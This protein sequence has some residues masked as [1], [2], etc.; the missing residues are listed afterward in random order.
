MMGFFTD[1]LGRQTVFQ[2]PNLPI[3]GWAL[4]GAASF[5]ALEDQNRERLRLASTVSLAIWAV[6]ELLTG[7]SGF[8]RSS[9]ALTLS[10]VWRRLAP[11]LRN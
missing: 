6:L 5:L 7:R 1:G 9:G 4:F 3:M 11:A 10:W 8:R 2:R